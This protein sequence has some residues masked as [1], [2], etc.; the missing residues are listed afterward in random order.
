MPVAAPVA[1]RRAI[2]VIHG[3]GVDPTLIVVV[4][5][6]ASL[7]APTAT[8]MIGWTSA[9]PPPASSS[10]TGGTSRSC[11]HKFSLVAYPQLR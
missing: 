5:T 9:A 1:E 10:A 6:I 11:I 2:T 8:A 7:S 4:L 3:C